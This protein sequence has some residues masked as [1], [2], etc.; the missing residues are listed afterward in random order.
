MKDKEKQIEEIIQLEIVENVNFKDL[1]SAYINDMRISKSK[2]LSEMKTII[3]IDCRKDYIL[4]ALGFA[5]DSV[6][7]SREEYEKLKSLPS[8]IIKYMDGHLGNGELCGNV[9]INCAKQF[10]VEI[11]E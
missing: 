5:K 9:V 6:V 8:K 2:P 11:K 1:K 10:G 7:L 3:T 4:E